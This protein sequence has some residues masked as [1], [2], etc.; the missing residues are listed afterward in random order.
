MEALMLVKTV[1]WGNSIW[2]RIPCTLARKKGIDVDS[3][4]EIDETEEGVIIKP[5]GKR[6]YSLKELVNGITPQNRH[7][8][9]DFG[10][11]V[12]KEII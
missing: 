7:G 10:L 4:V 2:V 1:Q 8:E 11:F 5:V 3:T 9:A 6:E 12:G